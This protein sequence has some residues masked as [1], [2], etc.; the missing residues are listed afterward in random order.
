MRN[1]TGNI[2]EIILIIRMIQLVNELTAAIDV[3]SIR[4]S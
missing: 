2:T 3:A 4:P 1:I